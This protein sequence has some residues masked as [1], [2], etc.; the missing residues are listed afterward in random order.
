MAGV[1]QAVCSTDQES[2]VRALVTALLG[3]DRAARLA[4]FAGDMFGRKKVA[5]QG[6]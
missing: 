1:T 6:Y 3:P 2:T 4:L 5:P